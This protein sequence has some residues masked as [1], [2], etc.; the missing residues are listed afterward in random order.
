MIKDPVTGFD[1]PSEWARACKDPGALKEVEAGLAVLLSNG[2]VL[3]R[4]YTTGTT[5]AA[6]CK[7]ALLSLREDIRSVRVRTACGIE[8]QV[9]V[10]V[11][12]GRASCQKYPGDYPEDA[13]AG[14]EFL[15]EAVPGGVGLRVKAGEGV[16]RWARDMPRGRRGEPA[17]SGTAMASIMGAVEQASAA[18]GIH[19]AEVRFQVV[20]GREAA[21]GTLNARMGVE[22]GISILGSTGLVEPWDDHLEESMIARIR[23]APR[24]VLTTGR[25]GLRSSRLL[26]PEHEAIL[27]GSKMT[28]AM[29]TARGEV[30]LCGLPGLI[31]RFIDPDIL[32]GRPEG[33]V[34][35][36]MLSPDWRKVMEDRLQ[37]FKGVHPQVRV[38]LVDRQGTII[39][40][41]G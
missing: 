20:G 19:D 10:H 25:S 39:G 16:G 36:L 2:K 24:V 13:T 22:G 28:R 11:S 27:V 12:R 34:E 17:I 26:F 23:D 3:R 5:A 40:D 9:P 6:A 37:R 35:E 18:A 15:A 8:V 14:L 4:G 41:S 32:D 33:T 29:E 1:Y 7:A 30:V 38:V 31:L 21:L